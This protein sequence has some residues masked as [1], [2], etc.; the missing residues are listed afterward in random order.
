MEGEALATLVVNK[1]RGVLQ[2]AAVRAPGFGDRRKAMLEDIAVL[3]G[4]TV[5][6]EDR[7]MNLAKATLADLGQAERITISKDQTTILNLASRE[8]HTM[9]NRISNAIRTI[10]RR[11][12]SGRIN[13]RFRK[14]IKHAS[15][16]HRASIE[17]A[18]I[19]P[20]ASLA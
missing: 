3:T 18:T 14:N 9:I 20:R 1:T 12:S 2:A 15:N 4:A 11:A 19:E 7:A 8:H 17:G 13:A 6:S 10:I 5:I 16:A